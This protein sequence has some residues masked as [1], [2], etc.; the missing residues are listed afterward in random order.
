MRGQREGRAVAAPI[1]RDTLPD[2]LASLKLTRIQAQAAQERSTDGLVTALA[3]RQPER[4]E[5]LNV[6]ASPDRCQ[7]NAH[8]AMR[9]SANVS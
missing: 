5:G 9:L 4:D 7:K 3:Q 2:P 8:A 6:A 1:S